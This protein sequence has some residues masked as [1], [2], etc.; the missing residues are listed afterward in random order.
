MLKLYIKLIL[1]SIILSAVIISCDD[2]LTTDDIDSREIPETNVSYS[3][4]IS[5]FIEFKCVNC[6]NPSRPDGGVDL[7]TWS[8]ITNP[9]I[10]TRGSS[11]TS[12]I[13]W[14]VE[15]RSGFSPMPPLDSPYLVL[16]PTQLRGLKTW[17]DEGAENN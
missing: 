8:G 2:S 15:R 17:I 10:M 9:V 12:I 16:T 6:H 14:T 7:S 11:E 3:L 5:P 1:L 4:H 13:V